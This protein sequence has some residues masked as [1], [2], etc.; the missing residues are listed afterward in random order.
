MVPVVI[1]CG[2]S[3]WQNSLKNSLGRKLEVDLTNA[4]WEFDGVYLEELAKEN[5]MS[6]IKNEISNAVFFRKKKP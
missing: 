3:D 6:V 5:T 1:N 2:A 4:H